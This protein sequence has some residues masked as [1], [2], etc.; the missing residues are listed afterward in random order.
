MYTY[1]YIYINAKQIPNEYYRKKT[2]KRFEKKQ[3]KD[4][5]IFLKKSKKQKQ[6]KPLQR[7]QNFSEEEK[8]ISV[9]IIVNVIIIANKI[10][11]KIKNKGY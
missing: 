11:L 1:I 7:Y 10:F 9:N 5:K 8:E 4:M 3:V 2:K 6:K